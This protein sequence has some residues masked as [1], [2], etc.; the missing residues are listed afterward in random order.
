MPTMKSIRAFGMFRTAVK[1]SARDP[2]AK[3]VELPGWGFVNQGDTT[4]ISPFLI[5]SAGARSRNSGVYN[6][7]RTQ[8]IGQHHSKQNDR[9]PGYW[10][11]LGGRGRTCIRHS[12][13]SRH[14]VRTVSV[15]GDDISEKHCPRRL[16]CKGGNVEEAIAMVPPGNHLSWSF[17]LYCRTL[18]FYPLRQGAA[19]YITVQ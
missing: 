16:A 3:T 12:K 19:H 7:M 9:L 1:R 15:A 5:L 14:S 6:G 11:H 4:S 8:Y 17:R 13:T 2:P 18:C 10:C